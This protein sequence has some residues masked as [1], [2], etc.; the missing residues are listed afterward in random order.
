MNWEC[1]ARCA[2]RLSKW[3]AHP[4]DKDDMAERLTGLR[5]IFGRS[6]APVRATS[7]RRCPLPQN[8]RLKKASR[9]YSA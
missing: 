2:T 1:C 7:R 3:I 9:R 6:L 5:E 8:A 4:V